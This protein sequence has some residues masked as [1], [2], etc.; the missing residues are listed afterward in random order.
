M[1]GDV[2]TN[3]C[4]LMQILKL[5]GA[6]GHDVLHVRPSVASPTHTIIE[7]WPDSSKLMP[8]GAPHNLI[9]VPCDA[10]GNVGAQGAAFTVQLVYP[11]GTN[12]LHLHTPLLLHQFCKYGTSQ[13]GFKRE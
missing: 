13:L 8:T 7:S 5:P 10:Y 2:S 6:P 1:E 3:R 4:S 11:K 12:P 9:I